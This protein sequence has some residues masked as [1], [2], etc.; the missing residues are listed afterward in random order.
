METNYHTIEYLGKNEEILQF[1]SESNSEFKKR[2]L[3]IKKLEEAKIVW[4]EANRLSKVWYN[5]EF[6]KC[7]YNQDLYLKVMRYTK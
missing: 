4:K 6:K 7:K 5:I 1:L 3:Y 2:L